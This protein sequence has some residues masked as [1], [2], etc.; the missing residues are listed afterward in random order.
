MEILSWVLEGGLA[1]KD[2]LGTGSTIRPGDLQRMS[3]GTGVLHS[4]FNASETDPVHFLQI[5]IVPEKPGLPASY[6]QKHFSEASRRDRLKRIASG[7][8]TNGE[9][10]IAQDLDLHAALLAPG[11]SV[12]HA[13]APGRHAWLH[14]ARGGVA[15]NG[16]A[17]SAGDGAAVSGESRV[18][19]EAATDAE[20]LLFDLA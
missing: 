13:L 1:H 3:A 11:A 20:V 6:D 12:E 8:P 18:V 9:L 5:W 15:L 7:T 19:L 17:L 2:S 16:L 14:V 10:T 4:E